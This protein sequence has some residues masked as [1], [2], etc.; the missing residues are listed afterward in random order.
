MEEDYLLQILDH[1]L[2]A[3]EGNLEEIKVVANLAKGCLRVR[4]E[5]R[6]TMKEVASELEG[7]TH[8]ELH[9]WGQYALSS[10][11]TEYLL[12]SSDLSMAENDYGGSC[13]NST[14]GRIESTNNEM[15]QSY[16]DG[17]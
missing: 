12:K 8:K 11:E 17:R 2:V 1:N 14:V 7:L 16:R 9:P 4:G 5:E 6:P 15:L 10:E 3:A 13:S